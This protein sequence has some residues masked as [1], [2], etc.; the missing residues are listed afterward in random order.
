MPKNVCYIKV[1]V[2]F[3]EIAKEEIEKEARE[4]LNKRGKGESFFE[5]EVVGLKKIRTLNRQFMKKDQPTDVLSFPLQEIP[6]ENTKLIG[7][8]FV[9][10]D[11]IKEQAKEKNISFKEEF[12]FIVRHGIDHLVGIHHK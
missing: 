9:C 8:I 2:K 12:V 3:L 7:T 11:I 4:H 5:L 6:G 1:R 10:S